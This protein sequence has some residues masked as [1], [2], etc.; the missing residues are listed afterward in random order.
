MGD[1]GKARRWSGLLDYRAA[2]WRRLAYLGSRFGPAFFVRHSPTWIGIGFG[3]AARRQRETVRANLRRLKGVR[4]WQ[5][6]EYDI[7]RTFVAYAHCLAESLGAER[8][9]AVAARCL[10]RHKD[11][12]DALIQGKAGF[13]I[14]TAHT[15]GWD[16]AAQSLL[17]H[18]GRRVVLVMEREVDGKAMALHDSIRCHRGIEVVHV[19]DSALSGLTLLQELKRGAIVAVQLDRLLAGSRT[20]EVP[21]GR[22][23]FP[24][25]RGPFVLASLAQ[26]PLLPLF[27]ARR[28]FYEYVVQ[29]GEP[30]R[31]PRRLE[32][33][34]LSTHAT[35][36]A[37]QLETFLLDYPEQWFNF[38]P[39]TSTSNAAE[40]TLPL[41]S[42]TA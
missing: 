14:A 12:L 19:G 13:I 2:E 16:V 36:V 10:V 39:A 32:E 4:P 23:S 29:V 35:E 15:G 40:A 11:T 33:M 34:Q 28:G 22:A 37:R 41:P 8:P 24:F 26:V 25:P 18:S 30:A 38:T 42:A 1:G 27:V 7:Q 6:E 9:E 31:L 21:L 5:V 17:A 20:V 3:L